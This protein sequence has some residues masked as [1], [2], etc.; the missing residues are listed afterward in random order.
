VIVLSAHGQVAVDR[1]FARLVQER[2]GESVERC[3]QCGKCV[4]GCPTSAMMDN[5]PARTMHLVRLGLRD[6]A[7]RSSAIW[8]CVGCETCTTRCPQEIDTARVMKTLCELADEAGIRPREGAVASFHRAFLATVRSHG[9][10][11][12]LGAM[13]ETKL[14]T[15]QLFTDIGLGMGMFAKGKLSLLPHRIKQRSEVAKLFR[16]RPR[17]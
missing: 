5:P 2:S 15:K 1:E 11:H 17:R 4:A 13:V 14:R 16:K 6:I 12:E 10:A 7:L 3:Y 8:L 9:R